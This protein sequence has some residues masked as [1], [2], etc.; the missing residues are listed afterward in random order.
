MIA[1]VSRCKAA[2]ASNKPSP[3]CLHARC[4]AGRGWNFVSEVG[5]SIPVAGSSGCCRTVQ[6]VKGRKL[7]PYFTQCRCG[8]R[9]SLSRKHE[10]RGTEEKTDRDCN[11]SPPQ[12]ADDQREVV[13]RCCERLTAHPPDC[14]KTLLLPV[15]SRP[16]TDQVARLHLRTRHQHGLDAVHLST[17]DEQL[18]HRP[19]RH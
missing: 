16:T 8:R 17:P 15:L 5:V 11:H 1:A 18:A 10:D 9:V 2:Y 7:C 13:Q 6:R 3:S 19:K 4:E 12:D 14:L